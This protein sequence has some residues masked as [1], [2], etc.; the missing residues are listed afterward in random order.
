M[1]F[2]NNP[3]QYNEGT[4]MNI[5]TL[6]AAILATIISTGAGAADCTA[7][8]EIGTTIMTHRQNGVDLSK[9]LKV[10]A[11]ATDKKAGAL[12]KA[13]AVRAYQLPRY[14]S[15]SYRQR[16]IQDFANDLTVECA[17]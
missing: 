4:T 10:A 2:K 3:T 1:P 9:I 13:L 8:H 16:A 15:E 17:K 6:T 11:E 5:K 14:Q 7:F 12:I